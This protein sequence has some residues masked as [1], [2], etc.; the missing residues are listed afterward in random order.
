M[1]KIL[2]VHHERYLDR[3]LQD[4]VRLVGFERQRVSKDEVLDLLAVILTPL[5]GDAHFVSEDQTCELGCP[6]NYAQL[7]SPDYVSVSGIWLLLT[8]SQSADSTKRQEALSRILMLLEAKEGIRDRS[9]VIPVFPSDESQDSIA[10]QITYLKSEH[11]SIPIASPLA[12]DFHEYPPDMQ[13]G[14]SSYDA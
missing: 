1:R 13:S 5:S 3:A 2:L 6:T 14:W 4:V 7:F 9:T 10:Q 11:H 12:I 8:V